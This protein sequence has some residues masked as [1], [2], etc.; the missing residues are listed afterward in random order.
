MTPAPFRRLTQHLA[1]LALTITACSGSVLVTGAHAAPAWE[2]LPA[3]TIF[4]FRMPNTQGFLETIRDNTIAGQRI[5]TA[6]RF[7]Q[8]QQLIQENNQED[9]DEMV[10]GLKEYGFTTDDLIKIAQSNWGMGIIAAERGE[11]E[12]PRFIMLGWADLAEED[13]DRIYTA[14]D[15]AEAETEGDE[16]RRRVDLEL[17]GVAVRQYSIAETDADRE[18]NWDTPDDF[19]EKTEEQQQAFWE[20]KEKLSEAVQYV[21]VDETHLLLTRTPG[22]LIITVGFPQSKDAVRELLAAGQEIDW[23][24]ATD[25]ESVQ[26]ALAHF[27]AAQDGGADDSFAARMLAEPDAAAAVGHDNAL[28]EFYADSPRMIDLI[29]VGVEM[30]EGAEDAQQFK[31]VMT[32]LGFDSLG[33]AT[34]SGYFGDST[35]QLRSFIQ[36]AGP[37][38]GLLATLDGQTLPPVPPAWVPAGVTYF[39]AAYDLGKLYDVV[40]DVAQQLGGPE[41]MQQVQMGNMMVQGQVQA[42]IP[43]ILRGLGIRHSSILLEG[44]QIQVSNEE[45]DY[46]T[47]TF[48]TVESTISMQPM[49]FVWDLAD[50]EAWTRVITAVKNF[51]PMAGPDGGVEVVDEQ[52]FTGLRIT[53]GPFPVA[54][55]LGQ[56][57]LVIGVGPDV[58]ERT[59]SLINNPPAGDASLAG[60]AIYQDGGALLN[61]QDGIL[62]SIQDAGKDL[63]EAKRTLLLGFEEEMPADVDP[64]LLEQIKQLFPSDEDLRASFGVSVGQ[65]FMTDNGMV[66]QGVTATPAAE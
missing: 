44:R 47:E 21:R 57:K 58:T 53:S 64:G 18:I 59:L 62:F 60:S 27:L 46:E 33:V 15:Q 26:A 49:G 63:V 25:V 16:E 5:F 6:E 30:E 13:I 2:A 37:R 41:V 12:L 31:T 7:T 48:K 4:A 3:E 45:Y 51:A 61:L 8:I 14:I 11:A 36:M 10:A 1:A 39:H 22:R 38:Q 29:A 65:A 35:I 43:T 20:E 42:D 54:V 23:D 32:A 28:F 66:Y 50:V 52:G 9:W 55:M 17:S 40:I 56:G 19:W 34:G 24:V